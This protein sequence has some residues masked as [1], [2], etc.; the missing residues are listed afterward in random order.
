MIVAPLTTIRNL[1]LAMLAALASPSGALA[2][3]L[4]MPAQCAP[5]KD[6]F[7]QNFVDTLPG[8]GVSDSFCGTATYEGHDGIDL[9]I[10]S[11]ADVRRG[12]AVTAVADGVVNGLR[13][14]VPD[15]LVET[16]SDA[17][18]VAGMDCGNGVLVDHGNGVQTQ[19]CHMRQDSVV[20]KKG[21]QVKRGDKL[22][23][24]GASGM[25]AFP[26]VHLTV[27]KDGKPLDPMTGRSLSEGCLKDGA[28]AKPLFEP[29]IAEALGKG[30]PELL[31][32]GLA[33]GPVDYDA[34]V[35][36]GAPPSATAG[37]AN[38]VGWGW[39]IN[40]HRGERIYISI[41]GPNGDIF[42]ETMSEALDRSKAAY[43][44]FT[45]KRG[46]PR[47]GRYQMTIKV[48]ENMT[49]VLQQTQDFTIE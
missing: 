19:Y 46:S 38:L 12:V 20:V 18:A 35:A 6:C 22:G 24:I 2:Q 8:E 5:G 37:S 45:G 43:S 15:R 16:E 1:A 47:P 27:R 17:A 44:S 49:P 3:E 34:L 26:H 30:G 14:G 31:G 23:E 10:R 28:S 9:R 41:V 48:L 40:L 4:G 11:M 39:F 36:D 7:L 29:G 32:L 33:G 25:A 13:D 42:A 21:D